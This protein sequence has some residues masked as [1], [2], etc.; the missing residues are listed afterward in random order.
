MNRKL[1]LVAVMVAVAVVAASGY[2]VGLGSGNEVG[3]SIP[4]EITLV[5]PAIA[6][7]ATFLD[8]E[9]GIS[10][11]TQIAAT[12]DLDSAASAFRVIERQTAD[13][14]VGTVGISGETE[15][16]D[17]HVFVHQSGWIVAY[18]P[19]ETPVAT[20]LHWVDSDLGT[21]HL[22]QALGHV[23]SNAGA[24]V[25]TVGF[26]NFRFPTAT[27]WLIIT[28]SD[29]FDLMIPIEFSVFE[30]SHALRGIDSAC[31]SN[32]TLTLTVDG[33]VVD[34]LFIPD[35]NSEGARKYGG[36]SFG[37][38]APGTPHEVAVSGS[39]INRVAI[40]LLFVTSN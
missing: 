29:T 26:F 30:R 17:P 21:T 35:R 34:E 31:C 25:N 15:E 11:Y 10:A 8:Q 3:S 36:I 14:F 33:A 18:Y 22:E 40:S 27:E 16:V 24:P 20:A 38:L 39:D 19:R 12:I 7:T 2:F 5:K 13:W 4:G 28:D 23:A 6:Q 37:Q 1:A 32:S 9:A